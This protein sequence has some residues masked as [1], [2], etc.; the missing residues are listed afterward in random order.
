[1]ADKR[2]VSPVDPG[3]V[4]Q[5]ETPRK[6]GGTHFTTFNDGEKWRVSHDADKEGK[7]VPGSRHVT[8]QK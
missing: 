8:K 5:A 3:G 2:K 1:M 4:G 7:E 6:G